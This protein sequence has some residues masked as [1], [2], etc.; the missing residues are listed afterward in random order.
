MH[1]YILYGQVEFS[2]DLC[3]FMSWAES[4]VIISMLKN[5]EKWQLCCINQE[6]NTW[7]GSRNFSKEVWRRGDFFINFIKKDKHNYQIDIVALSFLFFSSIFV[8][9]NYIYFSFY[10]NS[11]GWGWVGIPTLI[12]LHTLLDSSMLALL[13]LFKPVWLIT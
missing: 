10:L 6:I 5:D 13:F 7:R 4:L 9:F 1:I 2:F 8:L 11:K 3:Q 12:I